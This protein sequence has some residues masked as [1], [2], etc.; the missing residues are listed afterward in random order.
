MNKHLVQLSAYVG[1]FNVLIHMRDTA[2][3][4]NHEDGSDLEVIGPDRKAR[5]LLR[6]ARGIAQE[7]VIRIMLIDNEG[8]EAAKEIALDALAIISG[9]STAIKAMDTDPSFR[10]KETLAFAEC[11]A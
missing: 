2:R 3:T 7:A 8:S 4:I 9:L 1:A 6:S 11:V 10:I 5:E